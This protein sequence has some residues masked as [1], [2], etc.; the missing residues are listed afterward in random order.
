MQIMSTKCKIVITESKK[1]KLNLLIIILVYLNNNLT[2]AQS[3]QL[4]EYFLFIS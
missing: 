1:H 2:I 3:F 4:L